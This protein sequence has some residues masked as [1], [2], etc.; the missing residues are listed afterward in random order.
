MTAIYTAQQ[1]IGSYVKGEIPLPLVI[2]IT[3][4]NDAVLDLTGFTAVFEIVRIDDGT[5]PGNLGDGTASIPTPLGGVTQYVWNAND[6]LTEGA[7]RGVMWVGDGTNR[8]SSEFF[9][10][11]V[12]DSTTTVPVI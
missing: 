9:E 12:R 3:D 5:D 6:F 11:F 1:I 4:N 7:F 10:W 2:S 8:Y